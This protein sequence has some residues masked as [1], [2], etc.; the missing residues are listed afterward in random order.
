[1]AAMATTGE[2][3]LDTNVARELRGRLVPLL[4]HNDAVV[5]GLWL[6]SANG[7]DDG[8]SAVLS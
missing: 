3:A 7:H 8:T 4:L 2:H 5:Q 6:C 1:M